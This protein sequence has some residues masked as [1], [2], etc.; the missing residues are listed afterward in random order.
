[1]RK[2]SKISDK[3][4]TAYRNYLQKL[5]ETQQYYTYALFE[6]ISFDP[7]KGE[8]VHESTPNGRVWLF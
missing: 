8:V 5:L 4:L 7:L 2:D 6:F 1:M 3:K